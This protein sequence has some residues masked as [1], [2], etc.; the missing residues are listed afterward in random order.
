VDDPGAEFFENLL[1][2]NAAAIHDSY[3]AGGTSYGTQTIWVNCQD[4]AS[5]TGGWVVGKIDTEIANALA[6]TYYIEYIGK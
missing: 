6:G 4:S 5:A 3:V 1:A 2:N